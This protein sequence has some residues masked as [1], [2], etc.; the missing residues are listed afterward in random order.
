MKF[1]QNTPLHSNFLL[2]EADFFEG[3]FAGQAVLGNLSEYFIGT[4]RVSGVH[5]GDVWFG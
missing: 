1:I 2:N 5:Q 4:S 3:Y